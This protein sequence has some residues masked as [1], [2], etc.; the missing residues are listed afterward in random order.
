MTLRD[1]YDMGVNVARNPWTG[2]AQDRIREMERT[3]ESLCIRG[4]GP[5]ASRLETAFLLGRERAWR[6]GE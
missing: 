3:V 2:S 1:A 5:L 6:M 4:M